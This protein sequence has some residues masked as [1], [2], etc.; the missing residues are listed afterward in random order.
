MICFLKHSQKNRLENLLQQNPQNQSKQKCSASQKKRL[1]HIQP[2]NFFLLHP[3]QKVNAKF[4]ASFFQYEPNH[5]ANQPRS[6]QYNKH[7]GNDHHR[8]HHVIP[9]VNLY[10]ILPKNQTAEGVNKRRNQRHSQHVH[11]I[12]SG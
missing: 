11:Q 6:N 3:Q 7:T 2:R 8:S 4:T 5:V 10:K 12:I 9:H 1:A